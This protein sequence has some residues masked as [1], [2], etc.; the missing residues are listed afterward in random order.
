MKY[1]TL[2]ETTSAYEAA[3]SGL[4]MP[5]VAL[6]LDNNEVHYKPYVDPCKSEIVKTTYEWVEIG[7]IKWATKNVGA[8]T[9]TDYGQNFSWGGT[10]GYT[11]DHVSGSCH[12]FYWTDHELGDG[13]SEPSNM[14]KYNSTDGKNVLDAE[15]DAATVNM[16]SGWRMPTADEF[17]ALGTATTSAWTDSYEDSGVAG[18]VLTSKSD[19]S[20][21]LFFPAAGCCGNGS[22][23]NVG[24]N[25]YYWSSS[26]FSHKTD[27]TKAYSMVF[28]SGYV[29]W[30]GYPLR[31]YGQTVRGVFGE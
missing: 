19:I 20:K 8:L 4:L 12:A 17:Q 16:G 3:E 7:G 31:Y 6:T 22:V 9:I 26:L 30:T 13:G 29:G 2:H 10:K 25:G 27:K 23:Y 15:D 24:S 14:T 5:H 21:K 1:L 11:N 18:L 28:Y